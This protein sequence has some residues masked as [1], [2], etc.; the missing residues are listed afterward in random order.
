[1][2]A[3]ATAQEYNRLDKLDTASLLGYYERS[4]RRLFLLDYDGTLVPYQSMAELAAP[5]PSLLAT[6]EELT[7]DSHNAV[8]IISGR[9]K[10]RLQVRI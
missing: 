6:L 3:A 7:S 2:Q 9:N 1:L 8:Y 5:S 4:R 10:A